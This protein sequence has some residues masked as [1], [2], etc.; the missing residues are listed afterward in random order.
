M[1]CFQ[2]LKFRTDSILK[3]IIFKLVLKYYLKFYLNILAKTVKKI[4]NY[5]NY[6]AIRVKFK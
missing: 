5:L 6:N 3:I 1:K 2:K 4:D